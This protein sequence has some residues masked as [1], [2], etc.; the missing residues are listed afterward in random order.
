MPSKSERVKHVSILKYLLLYILKHNIPVF[1]TNCCQVFHDCE[2]ES[3]YYDSEC[4]PTSTLDIREGKS[5]LLKVRQRC[6]DE[7][8]KFKSE[9]THIFVTKVDDNLKRLKF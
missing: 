8:I 2:P 9:R 7:N 5:I 3:E 6:C 4:L 1:V